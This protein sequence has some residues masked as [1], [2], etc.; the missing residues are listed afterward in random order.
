MREGVSV[1]L[2]RELYA[3]TGEL[4]FVGHVRVDVAALYPSAFAVMTG[5]RP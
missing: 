3:G 2:L 4:A 5:V 1:Q